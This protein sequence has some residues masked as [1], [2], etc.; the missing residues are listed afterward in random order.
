MVRGDLLSSVVVTFSAILPTSVSRPVPHATAR[1][2]PVKTEVPAYNIFFLETSLSI[3]SPSSFKTPILSPVRID[4]SIVKLLELI[5]LASA[6][7]LVPDSRTIISPGTNNEESISIYSLSL[8]TLALTFISSLRASAFLVA[9]YSWIVDIT[10]STR[11]INI[12]A[13]ASSG[14]F[15]TKD[16]IAATIITYIIGSINDSINTLNTLFL[17]SRGSSL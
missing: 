7:I 14:S 13:S 2:L 15:A 8:I 10:A 11:I 16:N 5:I 12:I 9:L 6:D 4:S 17:F 3:A 1:A